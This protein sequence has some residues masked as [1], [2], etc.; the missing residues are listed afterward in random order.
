MREGTDDARRV[1]RATGRRAARESRAVVGVGEM[2]A[3]RARG[4]DSSPLINTNFAMYRYSLKTNRLKL[5]PHKSLP[6]SIVD[7]AM[8]S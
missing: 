6:L 4:M 8:P 3:W 7:N 1:R 2:N 5:A